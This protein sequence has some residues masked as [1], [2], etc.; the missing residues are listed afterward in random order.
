VVTVAA[1]DNDERPKAVPCDHAGGYFLIGGKSNRQV[2]T[3]AR[4]TLLGYSS[5]GADG[6]ELVGQQWRRDVEI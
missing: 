2:Q 5:L 4:G 1:E 6:R 3:V